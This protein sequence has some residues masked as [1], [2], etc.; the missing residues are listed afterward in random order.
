MMT[1][2][3]SSYDESQ[4]SNVWVFKNLSHCDWY[5]FYFDGSVPGNKAGAGFVAP[6]DARTLIVVG[7]F[8]VINM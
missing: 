5:K 3:G 2:L 7:S 1:I 6:N 8:S 4:T